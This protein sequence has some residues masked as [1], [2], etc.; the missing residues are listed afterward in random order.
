MT[1]RESCAFV[2][3]RTC[4]HKSRSPLPTRRRAGNVANDPGADLASKVTCLDS[5]E[6]S[7]TILP[8]SNLED[9]IPLRKGRQDRS[10]GRCPNAI[11]TSKCFAIQCGRRFDAIRLALRMGSDLSESTS[12][13]TVRLHS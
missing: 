4:I 9:S 11:F 13:N 7:G 3:V 10:R 6:G 12:E 8:F 2:S 1:N 5:F